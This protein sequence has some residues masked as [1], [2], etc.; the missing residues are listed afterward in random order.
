MEEAVAASLFLAE[1]TANPKLIHAVGGGAGAGVAAEFNVR[2]HQ[3]DG[4]HIG[5]SNLIDKGA[6]VGIHAQWEA[7]NFPIGSRDAHSGGC[8]VGI[9]F[10][11]NFERAQDD[12]CFAFGR[13]CTGRDLSDGGHGDRRG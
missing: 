5:G 13:R 2:C 10:S 11:H 7:A 8:V 1:E 6:R 3:H 12:G 4:R 9:V